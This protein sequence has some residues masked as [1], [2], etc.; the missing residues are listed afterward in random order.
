MSLGGNRV[1]KRITR[2]ENVHRVVSRVNGARVSPIGSFEA[3]LRDLS[4]E[5]DVD[6]VGRWVSNDA[7]N[8]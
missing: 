7:L 5:Q 8:G 2:R 4:Q 3:Q 6:S 1:Q